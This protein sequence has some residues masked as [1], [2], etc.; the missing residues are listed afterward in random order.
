MR[1]APALLPLLAALP[2]LPA[3]IAAEPPARD[4]T[5]VVYGDDPCPRAENPDEVVVCARR[6]EEERYRIPRRIRERQQTAVAWG[7]RV[8]G[9]EEESRAMRPGSCSVVGSYGFTGCSQALVRQWYADRR[10]RRAEGES[11]P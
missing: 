8:E 10:A 7:S 4:S 2:L 11:V 3:A 9:L 1:L 5:I 6:P